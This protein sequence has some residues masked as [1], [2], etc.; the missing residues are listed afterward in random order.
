[1]KCYSLERM[2]SETVTCS[3]LNLSVPASTGMWSAKFAG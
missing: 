1:M 2:M 3:F